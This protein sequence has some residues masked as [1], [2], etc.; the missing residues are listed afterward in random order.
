MGGQ[1][2]SRGYLYQS[3]VSILNACTEQTWESISVEYTT[4]NDKVDIALLDE[5][6][7]VINALQVKSSINLFTIANIKQWLLDLSNDVVALE[8]QVILIGNCDKNTN[9]FIKSIEKYYTGQMDKEAEKSLLGYTDFLSDKKIKINLLPFDPDNLIGVVRDALNRFVS[10]LGYTINYDSLD[11]LA[12]ALISLH[13]LFGTNSKCVSKDEY[14]KKISQWLELSCNGMLHRRKELSTLTVKSFNEQGNCTHNNINLIKITETKAFASIKENL[15]KKGRKLITEIPSIKIKTVISETKKTKQNNSHIRKYIPND[16]ESIE[17]FGERLAN[18]NISSPAELSEEEK[19]DAKTA[20]KKYWDID[21]TNDFFYV[22][23]LT[24]ST[25]FA[26]I[27]GVQ[28]E[29]TPS[30][31]KK[32]DLICDLQEVILHLE[33]LEEFEKIFSNLYRIP[34]C[35]ENIGDNSDSDITITLHLANSDIKIFDINSDLTC[36][37]REILGAMSDWLIDD[38]II[39]KLFDVTDNE[40]ISVDPSFQPYQQPIRMT[41]LG[42]RLLYDYD[43][44]VDCFSDYQ[45]EIDKAGNVSYDIKSLRAGE[46][47]WLAPFIYTL[48][49]E[50]IEY[51]INYSILSKNSSGKQ[52][53]K[54]ESK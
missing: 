38:D 52:F 41:P 29:G 25:M 3:I 43:D 48:I 36:D 20:I 49:D 31:T 23:N 39:S 33:L 11:E 24:K 44:F 4:S 50:K 28:Y 6:N 18:L 53:G 12:H 8:Y 7:I 27:T 32:N 19:N 54:I 40:Q 21:I 45:A 26:Q 42:G 14:I 17:E 15:L 10:N 2:G 34:L 22:G 30:E 13:M 47:K 5:N 35:I 9:N 16:P 51:Q 46:A 37:E 1:E